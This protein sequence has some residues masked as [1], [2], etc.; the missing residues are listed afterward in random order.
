MFLKGLE[1]DTNKRM[2]EGNQDEIDPQNLKV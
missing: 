2:S 1:M